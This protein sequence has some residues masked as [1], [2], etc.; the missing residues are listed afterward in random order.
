MIVPTGGHHFLC[1]EH[2]PEAPGAGAQGPVPGDGGGVQRHGLGLGLLAVEDLVAVE[3][4]DVIRTIGKVGVVQLVL[5][6]S[7]SEA[8]LVVTSCNSTSVPSHSRVTRSLLTR[9]SDH[10]LRLEDL[11]ITA[12]TDVLVALLSLQDSHVGI[13]QVGLRLV[14][15]LD[16]VTILAEKLVLSLCQ[17]SVVQGTSALGALEALLVIDAKLA[18]HLLSLEHLEIN[19][20]RSEE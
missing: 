19:R 16:G 8:L 7:A 15:V 5:A 14:A 18:R 6:L 1:S 17:G 10:L 11:A 2:L 12:R 20:V 9:F 13:V 4:V 3:A